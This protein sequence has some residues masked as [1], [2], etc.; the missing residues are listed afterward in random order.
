MISSSSLL[1]SLAW[2]TPW[3]IE[4]MTQGAFRVLPPGAVLL[5]DYFCCWRNVM[6]SL[7]EVLAQKFIGWGLANPRLTL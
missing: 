1:C 6:R 3:A 4:S 5:V 7:L 2:T